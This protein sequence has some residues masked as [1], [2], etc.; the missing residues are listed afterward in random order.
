MKDKNI[1][2]FDPSTVHV[3]LGICAAALAGT[4]AAIPQDAEAAI[5]T[6]TTPV[7]VPATLA[8]VYINLETGVTGG[9]SG[10]T[11]GWDFNPYL[12]SGGTQLGFYWS[13]TLSGTG[14][15][16]AGVAA[17][18]TT[19]PYLDLAIGTVVGSGSTFT[20]AILG[21]TGSPYL[22]TG[23]HILG[24]RFTNAAGVTN[25]GYLTM[26]N[27]AINGVT[28]GPISSV[29]IKGALKGGDAGAAPATPP[30]FPAMVMSWSF[31]N[32]GAPITVVPEPSTVA[33]LTIGALAAGA[34]GLRRWRRQRAA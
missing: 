10:G 4:A 15:R 29:D 11:P 17:T 22:M 21:T 13:P 19:G 18:S 5:I 14:L 24:F 34:A 25:Y 8:G 9:S 1:L 7:A 32:T 33:L 31:D 16:G 2:Q 20:S 26:S 3:R 6:F 23:T 27:T 30:G 12:A 28:Q